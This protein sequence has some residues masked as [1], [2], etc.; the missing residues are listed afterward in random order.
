MSDTKH[1]MNIKKRSIILLVPIHADG[2]FVFGLSC[3]G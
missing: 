1:Q 2:L 3:L